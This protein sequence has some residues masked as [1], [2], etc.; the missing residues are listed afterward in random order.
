[1]VGDTFWF[2]QCTNTFMCVMNQV[3]RPFIVKLVFYFD[4]IIAYIPTL[5]AHLM[6]LCDVFKVL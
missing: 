2:V 5:D 1:M 4:G 6:H 3:L